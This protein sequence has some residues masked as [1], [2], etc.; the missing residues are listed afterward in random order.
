MLV[1]F[2]VKLECGVVVFASLSGLALLE[3]R[4]GRLG[5]KASDEDAKA[6][7]GQKIARRGTGAWPSDAGRRLDGRGQRLVRCC[8]GS[9]E[10]LR[11]LRLNGRGQKVPESAGKEF[12]DKRFAGNGTILLS[13]GVAM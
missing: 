6:G 8:E 1:G 12:A 13:A 7:D 10:L 2:L 4:V 9:Y 5:V 11:Q 3:V